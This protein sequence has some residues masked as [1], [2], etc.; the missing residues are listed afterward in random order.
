MRPLFIVAFAASL[1]FAATVSP[2]QTY[3]NDTGRAERRRLAVQAA[4]GELNAAQAR[5]TAATQKVRASWNANPELQ[6]AERNLKAAQDRFDDAAKPVFAKLRDNPEYI[7]L[8]NDEREAHA[9]LAAETGTT[10]PS[11]DTL[12]PGDPAVPASDR[13]RVVVRTGPATAPVPANPP[14]DAQI[15]AAA[16]KLEQRTRRRDLED[17]AIAGDATASKAKADLDAAREKVKAL[18]TQ[19]EA[20]LLNDADVKAAR[21]SVAQA[22]ARVSQAAATQ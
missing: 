4:R 15:E 14:S 2:A 7:G 22:R 21:E 13:P 12:E 16:D 20:V 10:R 3:D 18:N 6:E 9:R 1:A 17:Q 11:D 8:L 5:L 19:L